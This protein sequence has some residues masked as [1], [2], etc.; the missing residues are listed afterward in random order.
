MKIAS[1]RPTTGPCRVFQ[2]VLCAVSLTLS[3]AIGAWAQ[4]PA[5]RLSIDDAV[6][7]A[8]EKDPGVESARWDWLAASSK[9]DAAWLKM[10]PSL[11]ASAGY[12][13]LSELPDASF[14]PLVIKSTLDNVS[15]SANLQYPV[16]AGFRIR[17]A[18]NLASLTAQNK[19]IAL[20]MVKR[21]LVFEV[22]R[23]Y[24]EAVRASANVETLKK[25]LDLVAYNQKLLKDQ[26]ALGTVTQA[27]LL[28]ADLRSK[29][30]EMD[31]AD[32]VSL[33]KRA[34]LTLASLTGRNNMAFDLETNETDAL[35]VF[36]LTTKPE[37]AIAF[38]AEAPLDEKKM[39]EAALARR[40][41]TRIGALSVEMAEHSAR[42][43]QAPLYPTL[44]ITGNYLLA[45]PNPRVFIQA[46][47][48][49]FTGTWALG[50]QLSY[51]LGG[52][53]ANLNESLSAGNALA[54]VQSDAVKTGKTVIL[55]VQTCIL[56]LNRARRDLELVQGMVDQA[57]ENLRVTEQRKNA[58]SA[59]TL[60]TLTAQLAL[61]RSNFAVTNKE[62]DLRIAAADLHRAL[63][64]DEAAVS[65]DP[66]VAGQ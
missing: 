59:S 34:W 24:W 49:V 57:R 4:V 21:S 65:G 44:S 64:G 38:D 40:P 16:F 17:E 27:D 47:P 32:A 25:N 43:A 45:N 15:F 53:P 14:G 22:R 2:I 37:G 62:I 8:L 41:E 7:A 19:L 5:Q 39:I 11:T 51:D 28:A 58:G 60:D 50:V 3:G 23:A 10:F 6:K 36:T 9:A 33:Q 30:A 56:N 35:E 31:L 29:Q 63:A 18:A 20:E 48:P 66:V 13:R 42:L 61:L 12:Q 46:D 54:K 26:T 52:L 1:N 55:D